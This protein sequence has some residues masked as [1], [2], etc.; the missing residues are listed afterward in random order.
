MEAK[1]GDKD[2]S[3][4]LHPPNN[5]AKRANKIRER[6][7][8]AG[9]DLYAFPIRSLRESES[10]LYYLDVPTESVDA[11]ALCDTQDHELSAL[12]SALGRSA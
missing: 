7:R 9:I 12:L 2:L 5:A 1:I 11:R 3:D 8:N 10:T 6:L 4:I